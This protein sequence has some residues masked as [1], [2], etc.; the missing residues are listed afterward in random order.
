MDQDKLNFEDL[1]YVKVVCRLC[2]EERLYHPEIA[3][4]FDSEHGLECIYCKRLMQLM[5]RH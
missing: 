3:N 5:G 1:G 4:Q 2:V